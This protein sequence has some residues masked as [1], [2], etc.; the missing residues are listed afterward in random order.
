MKAPKDDSYSTSTSKE[1]KLL[2]SKSK[3]PSNKLKSKKSQKKKSNQSSKTKQTQNTQNSNLF[4]NLESQ[5]SDN[6][7]SQ[8][9]KTDENAYEL[10]L[11]LYKFKLPRKLAY[12]VEDIL[13]KYQ[14]LNTDLYSVLGVGKNANDAEI[15]KAYR[16]KA[17]I[18]HPGKKILM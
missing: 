3:G 18:I 16:S 7:R 12:P 14:D 4:S 13:K 6:L 9:Q 8:A 17:L 5:L 10:Q 2:K 15:K 1:K 11:K